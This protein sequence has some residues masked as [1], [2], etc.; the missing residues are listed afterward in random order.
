MLEGYVRR[1]QLEGRLPLPISLLFVSADGLFQPPDD[2]LSG[3]TTG[4]E[5]DGVSVGER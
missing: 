2:R 1:A 4:D 3:P 5:V